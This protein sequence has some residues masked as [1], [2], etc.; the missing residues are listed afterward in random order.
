MSNFFQSASQKL[1]TKS[2][3]C[4]T[5]LCNNWHLVLD[6]FSCTHLSLP[7]YKHFK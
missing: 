3:L 5:D 6:Y 2:V 4:N 1:N 7:D